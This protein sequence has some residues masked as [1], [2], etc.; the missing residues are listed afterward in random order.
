MR[1]STVEEGGLEEVDGAAVVVAAAA[2]VAAV[3][4]GSKR[5][6]RRNVK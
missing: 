1:D 6:G 5:A 2:A 3:A 4:R